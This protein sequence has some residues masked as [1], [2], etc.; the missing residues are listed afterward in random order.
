LVATL[1]S[2][3]GVAG[4]AHA[5]PSGFGWAASWEY[6]DVNGFVTNVELPGARVIGYGLDPAGIRSMVGTV[7]DADGR[8]RYCARVRVIATDF[9]SP[10]A[11]ATACA[12]GSADFDTD[13]FVGAVFIHL[14]LMAG[15]TIVKSTF[16]FV[17][18]SA[19]DATL[20]TLG[21]GTSWFYANASDYHVEVHRPGV[22][23]YGDGAV[24]GGGKRSLLAAV[25]DSGVAGSCVDGRA[26]DASISAY[27]WTC[28]P[29]TVAGF[30]SVTFMGSINVTGC[31]YGPAAPV[32]CL[33]V[34]F[35]EPY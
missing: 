23:V 1:V 34:H 19:D 7:T 22:D 32:R 26:A 18:A 28:G 6:Y 29:G 11:T 21:T 17:P 33:M 16:T 15:N 30:N 4:T 25:G 12:G 20:R 10:V 24:Q 3:L 27:N 35:P 8:D 5:V 31:Y 9:S 13:E 2:V 14:D